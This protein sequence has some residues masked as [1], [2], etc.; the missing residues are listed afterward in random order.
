M[1]SHAFSQPPTEDASLTCLFSGDPAPPVVSGPPRVSTSAWASGGGLDPWVRLMEP[2]KCSPTSFVWVLQ[3]RRPPVPALLSG[4]SH[5]V[6]A[7]FES[8]A[9]ESP[10]CA[11][12]SDS[13]SGGYRSHTPRD[14]PGLPTASPS[15]RSKDP[16]GARH[17]LGA[18]LSPSRT[19]GLWKAKQALNSRP[20]G[21][22]HGTVVD[23]VRDRAI[24]SAS[25]GLSWTP[26]C[27]LRKPNKRSCPCQ[28]I[29]R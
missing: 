7:P 20:P 4:C 5:W 8:D 3:G 12:R 10:L 9:S 27:L 14:S 15:S 21:H 6:T 24:G 18:E 1:F 29:S 11:L 16:S 26:T 2:G 23:S 17:L 22:L 19:H 25:K 13:W 28:S